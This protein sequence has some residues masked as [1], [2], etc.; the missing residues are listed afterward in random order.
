MKKFLFILMLIPALCLGQ[1]G[2]NYKRFVTNVVCNKDTSFALTV[3]DNY[4]WQILI[5]WSAN[6]GD[7]SEVKI[8]QSIDGSTWSDYANLPSTTITG[9]TGYVAYED[10]YFTGRYMR[11][12]YDNQGTN[13]HATINCY[14]NFKRR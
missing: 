4:I 12:F 10:E 8:Q 1:S 13:E 7:S 2:L 5:K 9:A 3:S 6:T 11:V 14:Y